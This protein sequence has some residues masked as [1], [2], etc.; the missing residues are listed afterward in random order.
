MKKVHSIGITSGFNSFCAEYLLKL[1]VKVTA[2][3]LNQTPGLSEKWIDRGVLY[4]GA[5]H[6]AKYITEDLDLVV[7]PN[8]PIPGNP[9]CARA[10]ELNIPSITLGQLT[11]L[12]TKEFKV[13]AIAGTHGKTTT[14]SI[15]YMD[16]E[17]CF[18]STSK[19][20]CW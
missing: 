14:H 20:Y 15:C 2:S 12:V 4:P 10:E 1:G 17:K 3:E 7:F 13:I 16:V 5:Y 11:G 19:L 6:D 9:E 18:W 8:G